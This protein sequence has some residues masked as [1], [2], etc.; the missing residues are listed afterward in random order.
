MHLASDPPS[1][2]DSRAAKQHARIKELF[3]HEEHTWRG[4]YEIEQLLAFVMTDG[5]IAAELPR[6]LAEAKAL[7]LEF[8]SNLEEQ[9]KAAHNNKTALR[10]I[11]Q[12]LLNDLQ[13]FYNQRIRR[14]AAAKRLSKRV[15]Y[16]FFSAFLFFFALSFIHFFS[17]PPPVSQHDTSGQPLPPPPEPKPEPEPEP[18]PENTE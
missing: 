10:Y 6:R 9:I 4:A 5:Q 8:A 3:E 18:E 15:S 12:R 7:E 16:L 13:W 2:E 11:L 17:S 1:D 14:R